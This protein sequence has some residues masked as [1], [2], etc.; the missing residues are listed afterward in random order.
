MANRIVIK[1]KDAN[2]VK[3][4]QTKPGCAIEIDDVDP[5]SLAAAIALQPG[6]RE[7]L[8]GHFKSIDDADEKAAAEHA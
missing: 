6:L 4:E 1:A 3:N 5:S 2:I 8:E 7:E